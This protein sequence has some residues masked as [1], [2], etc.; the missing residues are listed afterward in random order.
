MQSQKDIQGSGIAHHLEMLN[1]QST[2]STAIYTSM[3]D[4]LRHARELYAATLGRGHQDRD[5]RAEC[6]YNGGG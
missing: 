6:D 2:P 4:K 3:S 5:E 1:R